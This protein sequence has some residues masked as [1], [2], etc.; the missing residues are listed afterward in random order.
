M[1]MQMNNNQL[2]NMMQRQMINNP[3]QFA[4]NMLRT[5]KFS[6]HEMLT[7]AL[8]VIASGDTEG[9]KNIAENVC[10]E[11]N[12]TVDDAMRQYKQYYGLN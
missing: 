8:N 9:A 11:H 12:V 1:P 7:N 4:Q 5:G 3:R 2:I 10:R 6:G